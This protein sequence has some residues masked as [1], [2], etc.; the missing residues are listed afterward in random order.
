MTVEHELKKLVLQKDITRRRFME[1]ALALGATTALATSLANNAFAAPK[2]GGRLRLGLGHGSTT[3]SMDPAT[4]ENLYMQVVGSAT[5]SNLM[6]VSQNGDLI[7][8][9]AESF[10]VSDDAKTWKFNL[11]KGAEFHNGKTVDVRRGG[12]KINPTGRARCPPCDTRISQC[13]TRSRAQPC[14]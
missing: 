2:K 10:D 4:F 13:D 7:P 12:A 5:R 8:E 14:Q 6:E 11:R 9:L 3:D 1:R